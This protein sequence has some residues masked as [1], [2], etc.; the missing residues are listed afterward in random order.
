MAAKCTKSSG[1]MVL[2]NHWSIRWLAHWKLSWTKSTAFSTYLHFVYSFD[3]CTFSL[4]IKPTHVLSSVWYV[5][6]Y[7]CI[8]WT[9][10]WGVYCLHN[11]Q[12]WGS[13]M[14]FLVL[15]FAW[16]RILLWGTFIILSSNFFTNWCWLQGHLLE[17]IL[18]VLDRR[19][20]ISIMVIP[21]AWGSDVG[22]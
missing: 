15:W 6:T 7:L 8:L 11:E 9:D 22:L 21:S 19:Q 2:N 10:F 5:I 12:L 13:V 14:D 16:K 4:F 17:F 20:S 3:M 18:H 1:F